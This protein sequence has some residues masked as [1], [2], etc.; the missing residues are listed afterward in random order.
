MYLVFDTETTGLP[1][2]YDA[3]PS[4]VD[5][6]PRIVQLAWETFG[7]DGRRTGAQCNVIRPD[8]FRIPKDAAS[9][10]GISTDIARR[11]GI[12][13]PE[14]LDAFSKALRRS[15]VVVSHNLRKFDLPTVRA[16]FCRLGRPDHLRGK[17]LI[18]T[19]EDATGYCA[20]PGRYGFKWPTLQELHLK[21]FGRRAAETHNAAKDVAICSKCFFELKRLR[22]IRIPKVA[23][24]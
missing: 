18:C 2:S 4:D 16:E 1:L 9:V 3:P 6:W 19:M 11:T 10:H 21:L 22:V 12:P 14:A 8:G 24:P 17:V 20:L 15:S 5:N 7:P 13:L 23:G